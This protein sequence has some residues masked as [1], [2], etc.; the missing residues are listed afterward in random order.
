MFE[1]ERGRDIDTIG[2]DQLFISVYMR[3]CVRARVR[4][5]VLELD[6]CILSRFISNGLMV[7]GS[8]PDPI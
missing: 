4:M 5:C 2:E 3:A 1:L 6:S 7:L 8:M